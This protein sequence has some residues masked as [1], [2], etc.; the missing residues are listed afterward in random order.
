MIER[1]FIESKVK[2]FT[3]KN[4][5]KSTLQKSGYSHVNLIT[6]P[7]GMKITIHSSKPGLI[8]GRRGANIKEIQR[9]LK[10]KFKLNNPQVE[11]KEVEVPELD[12]QI[13]A[14]MIATFLEKMGVTRFKAVG[15]RNLE[16]IMQAGAIG[17]E[18]IISGKVPGKRARSWR[19][20]AGYLPKCGNVAVTI[21]E[22]GYVA[23]MT[24]PGIVGVTVKILKPGTRMP[25]SVEFY[26]EQQK[27]TEEAEAEEK[28]IKIKVEE[29]EL[30]EEEKAKLADAEKK[31][32]EK[33]QELAKKEEEEPESLK[34]EEKSEE[35]KKIETKTEE[36]ELTEEKK[37][38]TEAEEKTAE[39]KKEEHHTNE[40]IKK[41]ADVVEEMKE[42]V[43]EEKAEPSPE[44]KKVEGKKG[45]E[46]R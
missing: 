22:R 37:A 7:L 29:K 39:E 9:V 21:V 38:K 13:M 11:V 23:A 18:V 27:K 33:E 15:H 32:T 25:D 34:E 45:E 2:E 41:C 14:S 10:D 20:Y 28:K 8:V 26:E 17:A 40:I 46:K 16:R 36:K 3:V 1:R 4:Y 43:Q 5:L 12:A 44:V 19:F 42:E 31:A 30:S 6:T 24:K 35:K